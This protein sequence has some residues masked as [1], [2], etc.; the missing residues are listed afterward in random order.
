MDEG[1]G[2]PCPEIGTGRRALPGTPRASRSDPRVRSDPHASGSGYPPP[3]PRPSRRTSTGTNAS[4]R[5]CRPKTEGPDVAFR[6]GNR[7]QPVSRT[8][9]NVTT[10]THP[11][12]GPSG[13]PDGL[14]YIVSESAEN[15]TQEDTDPRRKRCRP[16]QGGP[17]RGFSRPDSRNPAGAS[18]RFPSTA[19][20]ESITGDSHRRHRRSSNR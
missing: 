3:R 2:R 10:D 1:R 15:G 5:A 17:L 14:A 19:A 7:T 9:R 16:P 13:R 18:P 8:G 20:A 11:T 6:P 4:I 12:T